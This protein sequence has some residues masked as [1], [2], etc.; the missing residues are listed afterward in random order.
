MRHRTTIVAAVLACLPLAACGA[1]SAGVPPSVN[2]RVG[3]QVTRGSGPSAPDI[4]ILRLPTPST[5]HRAQLRNVRLGMRGHQV[6]SML[7]LA[8]FAIAGTIP[9]LAGDKLA[10]CELWGPKNGAHDAAV[11]VH[12][13][14]VIFMTGPGPYAAVMQAVEHA[15]PD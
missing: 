15:R 2:A 8:T 13:G 6:E 1:S 7:G 4:M 9:S 11:C 10:S 3:I 5:W 14:R 12:R